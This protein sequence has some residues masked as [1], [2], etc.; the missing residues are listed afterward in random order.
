MPIMKS[1]SVLAALCLMAASATAATA[2][3]PSV[4]TFLM[5]SQEVPCDGCLL[6]TAETS[7]MPKPSC[8][9]STSYTEQTFEH[10]TCGPAPGCQS[11]ACAYDVTITVMS[12]STCDKIEFI[13][14]GNQSVAS[15][16]NCASLSWNS[17][18]L[19]LTC[20][21]VNAFSNRYDVFIKDI[22]S[23]SPFNEHRKDYTCNI[24]Q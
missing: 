9:Q 6:G 7:Y 21:T 3:G 5:L 19:A 4:A 20:S 22:P 2:A 10:G 11:F 13:K 24:C 1:L 14:N 16:T 23:S 15:C 12:S 17:G 8:W 18:E